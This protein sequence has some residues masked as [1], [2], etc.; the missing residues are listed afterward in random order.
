MP[1]R[2]VG[3]MLLHATGRRWSAGVQHNA[4]RTFE[5]PVMPVLLT[6]GAT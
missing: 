5:R 1:L 6:S 2:F 3:M 4:R